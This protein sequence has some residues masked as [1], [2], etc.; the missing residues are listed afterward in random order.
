MVDFFVGEEGLTYEIVLGGL[1]DGFWANA[2]GKDLAIEK[3]IFM[4]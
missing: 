2:V 1:R 4:D 3:K